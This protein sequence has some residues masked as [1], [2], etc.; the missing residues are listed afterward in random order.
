MP[1]AVANILG[2]I[3]DL[4]SWIEHRIR[5]G[6]VG[7]WLAAAGALYASRKAVNIATD[8]GRR[9]QNSRDAEHARKLRSSVRFYGGRDAAN[10]AEQY[11]GR[12][13]SNRSHGSWKAMLIGTYAGVLSDV[14]F[15][16]HK[17]GFVVVSSTGFDSP[18]DRVEPGVRALWSDGF[19]EVS[20]DQARALQLCPENP[21]LPAVAE[22]DWAVRFVDDW[23][24]V[25]GRVGSGIPEIREKSWQPFPQAKVELKDPSIEGT[26]RHYPETP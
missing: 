6:T 22:A 5:L 26:L 16:L 10:A 7:D 21:T 15:Y 2:Q 4:A 23:G 18:L 20:L 1:H 12:F 17:G 14:T 9:E 25:W 11:P 24:F 8:Q 13:P 3:A 19:A